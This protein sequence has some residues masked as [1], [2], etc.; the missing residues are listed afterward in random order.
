MVSF[1]RPCILAGLLLQVLNAVD[2]NLVEVSSHASLVGDA[3][4]MMRK[5]S[6]DQA[7][8]EGEGE[9]G[10]TTPAETCNTWRAQPASACLNPD[11]AKLQTDL[12][13]ADDSDCEAKCCQAK[14]NDL[15]EDCPADKPHNKGAVACPV[16]TD[17]T[18]GCTTKFCCLATVPVHPVVG[19]G[20]LNH[21]AVN[22]AVEV[23]KQDFA[24][25]VNATPAGHICSP[26]GMPQGAQALCPADFNCM[27]W[28]EEQYGD[29]YV[30]SEHKAECCCVPNTED[31]GNPG[32]WFC[33][34]M[35]GGNPCGNSCK[36]SDKIKDCE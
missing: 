10:T 19:G 6:L 1:S 13:C 28:S 31:T 16:A 35:R 32:C 34:C 21:T 8:G 25:H 14:C 7:S 11:E 33:G 20:D 9:D 2:P 23:A 30:E 4:K 5:E 36:A 27:K 12:A 29:N 3:K 24:L 17:G 15:A 26:V 18:E 22:D